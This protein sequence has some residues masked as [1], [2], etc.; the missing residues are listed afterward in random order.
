M[1]TGPPLDR[2]V[3]EQ[4]A[5]FRAALALPLDARRDL[6][7]SLLW[8]LPRGEVTQLSAKLSQML[9]KDIVGSLPPEVGILILAQLDLEELLRCAL[10]SRT[11]RK[12]CD[13]QALWALLC[14]S[15]TPPIRPASPTWA[16]VNH[17]RAML[18]RR[19]RP[20]TPTD[21]QVFEEAPYY[22]FDERDRY[23]YHDLTA[24]GLAPASHR[25]G[26]VDPLGMSGGLRR[27]VWE[28]GALNDSAASYVLPTHHAAATGVE[29]TDTDYVE[30]PISSHL[31]V[32][33]ARPQ[34]NYKHLYITH[35]ILSKRMST[36][37]TNTPSPRADSYPSQSLSDRTASP[38]QGAKKGLTLP[39]PLTIDAISS[40]K[41]GGLPGHSEAIYSLALIHH[42]MTINM[43]A[44]CPDCST[45]STTTAEP[46]PSRAH[47]DPPTSAFDSL[48]TLTAVSPSSSRALMPGQ[49]RMTT[50]TVQGKEWLLSGSR[51]KT[52]RLWTLDGDSPRVVK[53]FSGGHEGSVLTHA[54]VRVA[55]LARS[56]KTSNDSESPLLSGN[57]DTIE[58]PGQAI[59]S[60]DAQH[61]S[62]LRTKRRSITQSPDSHLSEHDPSSRSR[63]LAVSGGS[64][65]RMCLWDVAGSS[66]PIKVIQAHQDSVLCVRGNGE[67][68]VS[69]SKDKTIKL[70]D[71]HTLKELLMI[72]GEGQQDMHRG[73]VNAVGL[74]DDYVISASGDK[75]IRV[76][77]I[78][79]GSLLYCVE[80]HDR[81]IAS[82]DFC[83]IPPSVPLVDDLAVTR[84]T[85]W[86]GSIVTGASD[87]SM[88]VYHLYE[89]DE[90]VA[91][92]TTR[93]EN[94]SHSAEGGGE[95]GEVEER[96]SDV[97]TAASGSTAPDE[98][99]QLEALAAQV[100][101]EILAKSQQYPEGGKAVWLMEDRTMWAPCA[102]PPGL[103]RYPY[104]RSSSPDQG[105]WEQGIRC[106]RCEN[107]G[108]SELVRTVS[109]G[110]DVIVSGSYDSRVKIWSRATGKHLV[111]LSGV[112]SGRVFSVV[113]DKCR[114]ISSG[115]DCRINLWNFAE[116]LDTSFVRA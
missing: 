61:V 82:I 42:P 67:R 92:A 65:G 48:L 11:W 74:S 91:L 99:A 28:R 77:S 98:Q 35:R 13:D 52:L 19:N 10:V 107:R 75:T 24:P 39:R 103:T 114:I 100:M 108:H 69:C 58:S 37:R 84:G 34:A 3:A 5:F 115:L 116:G 16:E 70:F 76:W 60:S 112:H 89:Q 104:D 56:A 20:R 101:T 12:L 6:A 8:S 105:A 40:V 71:V 18:H 7:T 21:E 72:G 26:V 27:T 30:P 78:S 29:G 49:K 57:G 96:G 95:D 80:A 110:S 64:D 85:E 102:C 43:L 38:R 31:A 41:A 9:Q 36:P 53:V 81:G 46:A 50:A 62:A 83:T 23:G 45:S 94:R 54:V 66:Q 51:D 47:P 15:S 2:Q 90:A 33:S 22:D 4:K 88:K 109:M 113:Q 1:A 25:A 79:T 86:K 55:P 68:V 97:S 59:S 14:V 87:A 63:V 32:P 111:D 106:L 44:S 17:R 93:Q 73:A